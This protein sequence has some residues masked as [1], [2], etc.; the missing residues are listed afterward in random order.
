[1]R[2]LFPRRQFVGCMICV[3]LAARLASAEIDF[4]VEIDA[5]EGT[6][7]PQSI[8]RRICGAAEVV[9]G[10]A[11]DAGADCVWRAYSSGPPCFT[12]QTSP[13][14]TVPFVGS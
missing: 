7:P 6:L 8:V 3:L 10:A 4:P 5:I 12:R 1:M 13:A 2:S 11:T 9:S 14:L